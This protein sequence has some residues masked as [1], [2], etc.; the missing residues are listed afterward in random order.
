M[1]DKID[2]LGCRFLP[3]RLNAEQSAQLLG[4]QI[5][6][7]PILV[8]AGLLYP[9]GD[10]R[11]GCVRYFASVEIRKAAES[12]KWL[13]EASGVINEH[14]AAVNA[15]RRAQESSGE[16]ATGTGEGAIE[17]ER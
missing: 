4:F 6:D 14:V 15:G 16:A 13:D 3:G 5:W 10:P 1:K 7:I 8:A 2:I 11:P 12:R 9:L 17:E